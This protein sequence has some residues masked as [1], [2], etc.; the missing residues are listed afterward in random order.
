MP[1][2]KQQ[3]SNVKHGGAIR[4]NV[5]VLTFGPPCSNNHFSLLSLN[6]ILGLDGFLLVI[7]KVFRNSEKVLNR[8]WV[9]RTN[10]VQNTA[11]NPPLLG[12]SFSNSQTIK[13]QDASLSYLVVPL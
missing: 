3:P 5:W 1:S 10:V 4:P 7:T 13:I 8:C 12:K 6:T 9:E 11:A 2:A